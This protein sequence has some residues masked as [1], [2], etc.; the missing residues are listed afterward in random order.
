MST[1]R[2]L[3][4]NVTLEGIGVGTVAAIGPVRI[5]RAV[6]PAPA[7]EPVPD[8]EPAFEAA[9]SAIATALAAVSAALMRAAAQQDDATAAEVLEATAEIAADPEL[10]EQASAA[11]GEGI[12]PAN[13][14]TRVFATHAQMFA[15]MGGYM[16]ER[17]ADLHAVRDRVVARLLGWPEP[18]VPDLDRPSVIIAE[19]LTPA[20]TLSLP[21]ENVL[22]LGTE[23]GGPTAHTA[24]IARQLGVPC[25]VR[26]AGVLSITEGTEVA[27]DAARG[28]LV[29]DPDEALRADIH[30]RAARWEELR[31]DTAP[32]ATADGHRIQLLANI[33]TVED[34]RAAAATAAEGV[35]LFRTEFLFL[36]RAQEPSIEEQTARYREVLEAFDGRKVVIRTLDAG[37][38]KPIAFAGTLTEANPALG[39]R[40][41]RLS[42]RAPQVLRHQLEALA[43]AIAAVPGADAQVMAPMIST[44]AE[45]REFQALATECGL[46]TVGVMVEVPAAALTADRLLEPLDFASIG[47]NDLAQYTM[48]SDRELGDL[49]DL[50]DRWQ[51]AIL[52]LIESTAQAGAALGRP[53]GV[54][55]ESAADPCMALVL[56]GLGVTSLSMSAAAIPPVRYALRRTDLATCRE[57]A[58]AALSAPDATQA[59]RAVVSR[60]SDEVREALLIDPAL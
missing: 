52:Q 25:L 17:V 42:R 32:G 18:G 40:A 49:A 5:L 43:Q 44:P 19:D 21:L 11:M 31:S 24:I 8:D 60:L 36:G 14:V 20:D 37:A 15:E 7:D 27:V 33:G 12:G 13:A 34:A 58:R 57:M 2:T 39:V 35:G 53:V 51:P 59:R 55:G 9:E 48:A 16:A 26:T 6:A 30:E 4:G 1:E 28:T 29:V 45:A 10:V 54:C 41:Y 3:E 38:D 22:A 56:C 46:S 47:T 23:A 50:I